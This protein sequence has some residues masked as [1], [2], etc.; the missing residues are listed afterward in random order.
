MIATH[1]A[2]HGA[3]V[4]AHGRDTEALAAVCAAIEADGGS[5]HAVVGDLADSAQIKNIVLEAEEKAGSIDV[6]VANAGGSPS[7][8]VPVEQMR[9]ED[10]V[11]AVELNLVATYRLVAAV[12]PGMKK[13]GRGSIV[14]IS[15]AAARRPSAHSPIAYAAAKA[16]VELLTKDVALQAGPAGIRAN[17]VAP[18]TIITERT[19]VEIPKDLQA[20]LVDQQ[21][22][23]RL[24]KPLDV[25]EA[26]LYLA[27]D[28]SAWVTGVVLD[29]AGGAVITQ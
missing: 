25:A 29:I 26:V 22:I 14:T 5:C 27:G 20:Q 9:D 15:S 6:L 17:C 2:S 13:R 1:L 3:R 8:P 19:D 11:A 16:G 28:R 7:K 23:R 18:E 24:G 10:F 21:P 12:L 4:S